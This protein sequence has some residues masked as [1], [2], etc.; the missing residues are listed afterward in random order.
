MLSSMGVAQQLGRCVEAVHPQVL[1]GYNTL[2]GK[3]LAAD[4]LGKA[5]LWPGYLGRLPSPGVPL[6]A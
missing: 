4:R 3:A 1:Q 2:L 5:A 6:P